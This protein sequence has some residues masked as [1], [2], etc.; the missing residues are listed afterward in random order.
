MR[1]LMIGCA[2]VALAACQ[3]KI[4]D[5]AAGVGFDNA[6]L[7][8]RS[9]P[10]METASAAVPP[11]KAVSQESLASSAQ[12]D[13]LMAKL[14][15]SL[16]PSHLKE[17]PDTANVGAPMATTALA[18]PQPDP[19][20]VPATTQT[21][22]VE[23]DAPQPRA[24][25]QPQTTSDG[26]VHASPSNPA[27]V[28]MNNPGISDENDFEAVGAR[29]SIADDAARIQAN[30]QNYQVIA[31]TA[32]PKRENAGPNIVAYALSLQHPVGTKVH[33]RLNL[34]PKSSYAKACAAYRSDNEAQADFLAK[35]GPKRDRMGLDPDG[36]G[37]ACGWNPEP[38]RAA[39]RK[40]G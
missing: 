26:I 3:P 14:R 7:S 39:A 5:S 36:D 16:T 19:T 17:T 38:Y 12:Q 31:P 40:G 33:M 35:G 22:S 15:T 27:P 28:L 29:R 20:P 4:P 25:G 23:P 34:K 13:P 32:L 24:P 8:P 30:R 10:D 6:N 37:Y 11:A 21:A 9:A 18:V 1:S 2:V